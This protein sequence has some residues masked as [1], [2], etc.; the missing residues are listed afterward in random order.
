[1]RPSLRHGVGGGRC[2]DIGKGNWYRN[3]VD[4]IG[5]MLKERVQRATVLLSLV[6]ACAGCRSVERYTRYDLNTRYEIEGRHY[7]AISGPSGELRIC[8]DG[9]GSL[10]YP[11]SCAT[12]VSAVGRFDRGTFPYDQV[13]AGLQQTCRPEMPSGSTTDVYVVR[14][15]V[16]Q[17][18]VEPVW[19]WFSGKSRRKGPYQRTVTLTSADSDRIEPLFD[20]AVAAIKGSIAAARGVVEGREAGL[21]EYERRRTKSEGPRPRH[22]RAAGP[23]QSAPRH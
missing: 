11:G 6:A 18:T 4:P 2:D 8:E 13:V 9:S 17:T 15:I 1:M 3:P 23:G 10:G 7:V 21:Q 16:S 14:M 19:N 5:A 12:L 22:D 20:A